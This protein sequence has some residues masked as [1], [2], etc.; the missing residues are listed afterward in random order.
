VNSGQVLPMTLSAMPMQPN[1]TLRVWSADLAPSS[2]G[3]T[4]FTFID[5]ANLGTYWADDAGRDAS[6]RAVIQPFRGL[7]LQPQSA[8]SDWKFPRAAR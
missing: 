1:D 2:S 7:F 3:Y 8:Q 5:A 4:A 6:A